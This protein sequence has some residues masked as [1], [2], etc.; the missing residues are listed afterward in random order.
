MSAKKDFLGGLFVCYDKYMDKTILV[1]DQYELDPTVD[2]S[3][4]D[5][6]AVRTAVRAVLVDQTGHIALMHSVKHNY[7]KLSGGSVDENEQL[8]DALARELLEETGCHAIVTDELGTVLEWR[9]FSRLKQV[10]YAYQAE[11]QGQPGEPNLTES[12]IEEGFVLENLDEAIEKVE[13]GTTHIAT[14]IGFMSRRDAEIL[15]SS[16]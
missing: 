14:S 4:R 1:L 16:Q 3:D 9:D 6:Y 8:V 11:L 10:S 5:G 2:T 13:I 7:Y 15:R 12:E